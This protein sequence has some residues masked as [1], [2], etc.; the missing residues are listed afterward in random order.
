M[1]RDQFKDVKKV[2]AK[3]T[4]KKATMGEKNFYAK[5]IGKYQDLSKSVGISMIITTS[6]LAIAFAF[7]LILF[8]FTRGTESEY[9]TW[10]FVVWTSIFAVSFIFT[11]VWYIFI[12]PSLLRKIEDYRHELER[13]NAQ[14][15]SKARGIYSLYGE[16]Y[17]RKQ[18]KIHEEEKEKAE[19]EAKEKAERTAT[20]EENAE[21][22]SEKGVN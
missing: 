21:N 13:I 10:R 5:Q 12:K 16:D 14:S 19:K 18:E 15:L 9:E 7:S 4:R 17:K 8:I 1:I 22:D 20:L 6:M 11:V 2:T 3:E